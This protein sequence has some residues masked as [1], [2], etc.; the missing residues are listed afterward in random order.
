M[1][2]ENGK[3]YVCVKS[4]SPG[5]KAGQKYTAYTRA[6][7]GFVC[8]RGSDGFEDVCFMLVSSFKPATGQNVVSL[9]DS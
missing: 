5:Y 3:T 8:F 7:D 9:V 4:A 6:K 2:F 1:K